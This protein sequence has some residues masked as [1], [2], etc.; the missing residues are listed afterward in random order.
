MLRVPGID[1]APFSALGATL[2]LKTVLLENQTPG[3]T[4]L[5]V[6][7]PVLPGGGKPK[8][9]RP[10]PKKHADIVKISQRQKNL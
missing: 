1:L 2:I 6:Q 7:P 9:R 10:P 5:I 4:R 8:S 3:I